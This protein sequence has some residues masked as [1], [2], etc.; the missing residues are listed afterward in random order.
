MKTIIQIMMAMLV[1]LMPLSAEAKSQPFHDLMSRADSQHCVASA[2]YYE[3]LGESR[4]GKIAVA[5]V[6]MNRVKSGKYASTPC[7]V[8]YQKGQFSW[9][10]PR[11]RTHVYDAEKWQE[12][13]HIAQQVVTGVIPDNTNGALYFHNRYVHPRDVR[14]RRV[15]AVIGLHIFLK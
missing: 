14:S 12:S 5:S 3:A 9:I 1:A 15:T 13:L 6:V 7:G 4:E 11:Y 2:V 10:N 8:I